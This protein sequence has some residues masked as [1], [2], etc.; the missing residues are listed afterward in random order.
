MEEGATIKDLD[1]DDDDDN[2]NDLMDV[3]S[4][5]NDAIVYVTAGGILPPRPSSRGGRD[6]APVAQRHPPLLLLPL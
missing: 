5:E 2:D 4:D 3:A 1:L 6:K